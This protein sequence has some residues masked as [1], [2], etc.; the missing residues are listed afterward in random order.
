MDFSPSSP[1]L[2]AL[3]KELTVAREIL[4]RGLNLTSDPS[5]TTTITTT[6]PL[7]VGFL[8]FHPSLTHFETTAFP[9]LR[10]H[11]P[12]AVWLFAPPVELESNPEADS[13][14]LVKR[15]VT[16]LRAEGIVVF[17]QVG[18]VEA[19]REAVG[20]YGVDVVVA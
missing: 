17:F 12:R 11:R 8:L 16:A 9:I 4:G 14:A 20:L 1:Q 10:R 5:T 19:A 13:R 7:G 18:N 15:I 3:D 2:A 6:L